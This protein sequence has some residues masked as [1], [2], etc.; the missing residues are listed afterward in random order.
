[1]PP[2]PDGHRLGRGRRPTNES[3]T[4]G[5]CK[6]AAPAAMARILEVYLVALPQGARCSSFGALGPSPRASFFLSQTLLGERPKSNEGRRRLSRPPALPHYDGHHL[7]T[8]GRRVAGRHAV[9]P[10]PPPRPPEPDRLG[11]RGPEQRCYRLRPQRR[12]PVL[13]APHP[14]AWRGAGRAERLLARHRH[15]GAQTIRPSRLR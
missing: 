8:S 15:G 11:V 12:G 7:P 2:L 4:A 9:Q 6:H 5:V 10:P 13:A 3:T 14:L 1:V